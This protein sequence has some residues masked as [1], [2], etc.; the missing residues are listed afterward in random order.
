MFLT[1]ENYPY[2]RK[3]VSKN[4]IYIYLFIYYL[5]RSKKCFNQ[6][7]KYIILT[8]NVLDFRDFIQKY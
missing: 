5:N 7:K 6:Y 8:S 3:K 1:E 2:D 4:C